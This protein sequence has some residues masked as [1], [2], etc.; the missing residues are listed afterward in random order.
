MTAIDLKRIK[1]TEPLQMGTLVSPI[2]RLV[3]Q[4][5]SAIVSINK[6]GSGPPFYCV[7]SVAGDVT[8]YYNLA[9]MLGPDQPFYGIQVCKDRM[10]ALS[11][12]SIESIAQRYVEELNAFQPK[13]A[14]I[15]GGFSAGAIIALEVAQQL[16]MMGRDVPLLVALDGA[17]NNTGAGLR[18]WQPRYA[19]KLLCNLPR[20][21]LGEERQN[22]SPNRFAGR[23]RRW[24][25]YRSRP[26]GRAFQLAET[27]H[28]G[29]VSHLF[30]KVGWKS[31]QRLFI[32]TIYN[33]MCVYIPKPYEGRVLVYET[34]TQP[35]F[36][37]LQIGAA[38]TK[39]AKLSQI[40]P[41]DGKHVNFFR[42]D[43][44]LGPLA[45]H[46]RPILA[47]LRRPN[48]SESALSEYYQCII[49]DSSRCFQESKAG[50]RDLVQH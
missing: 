1:G 18:R 9:Q 27:L 44:T 48:P 14:L 12:K 49:V 45:E 3:L 4:R 31:D 35:L 50:V 21:L 2:W 41:L 40:V 19:W 30:K 33:A 36:H 46:L 28:L 29:A 7:H 39:I 25:L 6:S 32:S 34:R 42:G 15:I 47:E 26:A 11:A 17:P 23:L 16:R 22:W 20:W 5:G 43:E 10:N 13:G 37:L 38:W 8:G 24:S